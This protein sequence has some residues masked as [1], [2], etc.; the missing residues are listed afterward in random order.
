MEKLLAI[1]FSCFLEF[2]AVCCSNWDGR[3]GHQSATHNRHIDTQTRRNADNTKNIEHK[4]IRQHS[5]HRQHGQHV[6]HIQHR[7]HK[8]LTITTTL[9]TATITELTS[10][11]INKYRQERDIGKLRADQH[12]EKQHDDCLSHRKVQHIQQNVTVQT[13]EK[14]LLYYCW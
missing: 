2:S 4:Q 10:S 7:Q 8:Q 1:H 14:Y 5:Q 6:E 3:A 11:K 13:I 9:A 12:R